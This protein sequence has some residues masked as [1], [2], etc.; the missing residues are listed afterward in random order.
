[1]SLTDHAPDRQ[2]HTD[3]TEVRLSPAVK[4]RIARAAKLSNRKTSDF[5]REAAS[6]RADEILAAHEQVT[7]V[8]EDYFA[9][10]LAALDEPAEVIDPLRRAADKARQVVQADY[11]QEAAR[12]PT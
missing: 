10:L 5:I 11:L 8:P 9:A 12:V 6:E 7:V 2:L 3:R 1:M 4:A